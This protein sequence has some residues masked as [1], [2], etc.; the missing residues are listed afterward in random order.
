MTRKLQPVSAE[1]AQ[2][3]PIP[4]NSLSDRNGR[5]NECQWNSDQVKQLIRPVAMSG[6]VVFEEAT[7]HGRLCQQTFKDGFTDPVQRLGKGHQC[8]GIV[9]S[10][11]DT[12]TVREV[13]GDLVSASGSKKRRTVNL[14]STFRVL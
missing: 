1:K 6:K 2:K 3:R 4:F 10:R 14:E 11:D 13:G 8:G 5:S 9:R 12:T 7:N